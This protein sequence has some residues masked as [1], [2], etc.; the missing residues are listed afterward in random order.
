MEVQLLEG[1]AGK[2]SQ[3]PDSQPGPGESCVP[4]KC[5]KPGRTDEALVIKNH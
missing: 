3:T 5:D 2:A 1:K 4:V